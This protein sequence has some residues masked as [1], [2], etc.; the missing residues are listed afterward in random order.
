METF[1]LAVS[2]RPL[3][4]TPALICQNNLIDDEESS[5]DIG[6]KLY[7]SMKNISTVTGKSGNQF[8]GQSINLRKRR[9]N[10][11]TRLKI[12]FIR[13][14]FLLINE[15]YNKHKQFYSY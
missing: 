7:H 8:R 12:H 14:R 1:A 3:F 6:Q 4:P 15:K 9:K 5:L 10:Y 2:F 13:G 11:K